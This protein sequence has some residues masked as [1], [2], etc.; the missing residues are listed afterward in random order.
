[1]KKHKLDNLFS[2]KLSDYQHQPSPR[3]WEALEESLEQKSQNFAWTWVGIAASA[4]LV[5][6]SSWYML[7]TGS[8]MNANDYA[9]AE[10]Q[11]AVDVPLEIVLVPVF[12]QAPAN[13]TPTVEQQ[14]SQKIRVAIDDEAKLKLAEDRQQ[15]PIVLAD[16]K[17]FEHQLAPIIQEPL[18]VASDDAEELIIASSKETTVE[19]RTNTYE[20]LTI[21]YKQGEPEAKSNFTKAINYMEDVRNGDKKLVNFKKIGESIKSKFKSNKNVNSK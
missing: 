15:S 2:D 12:I 9:Y 16:N 3:A 21:I 6:F 14:S 20:P 5:V 19:A 10:N 1:M 13:N 11:T 18:P 4:A 8:S 7:S 17:V